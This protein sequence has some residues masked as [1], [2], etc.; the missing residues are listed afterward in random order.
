MT[1]PCAT[2]VPQDEGNFE[3]VAPCTFVLHALVET[4]ESRRAEAIH[5]GAIPLLVGLMNARMAAADADELDERIHPGAWVKSPYVGTFEA[6]YDWLRDNRRVLC[7]S[8]QLKWDQHG[9]RWR[10]VFRDIKLPLEGVREEARAK[11][12]VAEAR[13]SADTAGPTAAA[14]AASAPRTRTSCLGCT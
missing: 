3:H 12:V 14:A 7:K 8:A 2:L 1:A 9:G 11:V 10:A 4:S 5:L 6:E 13:N